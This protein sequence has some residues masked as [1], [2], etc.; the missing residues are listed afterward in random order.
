[1]EGSQGS[2]WKDCAVVT[3]RCPV[4]LREAGCLGVKLQSAKPVPGAVGLHRLTEAQHDLM[5][6]VVGQDALPVPLTYSAGHVPV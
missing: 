1:M 4:Q 2:G 6:S 5:A 3:G